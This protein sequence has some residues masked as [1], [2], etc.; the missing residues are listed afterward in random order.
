MILDPAMSYATNSTIMMTIYFENATITLTPIS[1]Q[2]DFK[3]CLLESGLAEIVYRPVGAKPYTFLDLNTTVT[4]WL[5]LVEDI[6]GKTYVDRIVNETIDVR[7]N[8][9][10]QFLEWM[11]Q[12]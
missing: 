5:S 9:T 6:V 10:E 12:R 8:S 7:F 4:L 2:P 11:E 1:L 3:K